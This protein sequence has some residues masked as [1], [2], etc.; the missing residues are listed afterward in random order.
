VPS[1]GY[2]VSISLLLFLLLVWIIFSAGINR[3]EWGKVPC[4]VF[5]ILLQICTL[6][7]AV[8]SFLGLVLTLLFMKESYKKW[9][10][11][12][13]YFCIAG[14]LIPVFLTGIDFGVLVLVTDNLYQAVG[15][16]SMLVEYL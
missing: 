7:V 5:S 3:M 6:S 9:S 2:F 12:P 4:I 10:Q 16:P 14:L 8:W 1:D 15:Y 13:Y 11:L